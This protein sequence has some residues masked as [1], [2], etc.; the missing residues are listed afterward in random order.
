MRLLERLRR[1]LRRHSA[2]VALAAAA[3]WM[4]AAGVLAHEWDTIPDAAQ[5]PQHLRAQLDAKLA[6]RARGAPPLPAGEHLTVAANVSGTLPGGWLVRY[7]ATVRATQEFK[8]GARGD[9]KEPLP[10][11]VRFEPSLTVVT[12]WQRVVALL[13]VLLG[14]TACAVWARFGRG[15]DAF[16]CYSR[17]DA[18]RVTQIAAALDDYGVRTCMDTRGA[19]VAGDP[20]QARVARYLG[21]L[22]AAVVFVGRDGV[23]KG[24]AWEVSLITALAEVGRCRAIVARLPGS[25]AVPSEL[26]KYAWIEVGDGASGDA[27]TVREM[28]EAL[29]RGGPAVP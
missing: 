17:S 2:T 3:A 18:A 21:G 1:L 14:L 13:G 16:V 28:L 25:A 12:R 9:V 22:R 29:D 20:W 15:Y 8:V 7:V 24:Q 27:E 26:S 10:E 23:A 19:I 6:D 11:R 4:M 5:A